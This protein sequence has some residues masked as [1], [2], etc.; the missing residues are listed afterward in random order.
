MSH[1][2]EVSIS[3]ATLQ[4]ADGEIYAG[5]VLTPEGT[6]SHHLVLLPGVAEDLTWQ[7]ATDWAMAQGGALPTRQEQALLY[8]NA[9]A[10]FEGDWYWSGEEH[11]NGSYAWF[12]YFGN[13]IQLTNRKSYEGRARA[14]RRLT[15]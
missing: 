5:L 13:G 4:L 7:A 8:A 12:Q 11:T 2:T 6:P 3:A 1:M 9:K 10:H 15:A 14:V